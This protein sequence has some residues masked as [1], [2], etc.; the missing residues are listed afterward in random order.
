MRN[1]FLNFSS[2]SV[3]KKKLQVWLG[4]DFF[5]ARGSVLLCRLDKINFLWVRRTNNYKT[6]HVVL[7][8]FLIFIFQIL[9]SLPFLNLDAVVECYKLHTEHTT[10]Q[11]NE[12]MSYHVGRVRR[13]FGFSKCHGNQ[14]FV[15]T[16]WLWSGFSKTDSEPTFGFPHNPTQNIQTWV[17]VLA[18]TYVA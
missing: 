7:Y 13:V 8:S 17:S 9:N 14:T 18:T 16:F 1:G 10:V 4:F 5:K 2:F 3:L 15:S 11:R 6:V 12:N